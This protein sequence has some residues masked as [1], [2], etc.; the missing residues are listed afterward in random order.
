MNC[1]V[2]VENIVESH[3]FF[4]RSVMI[5]PQRL[6]KPLSNWSRRSLLPFSTPLPSNPDTPMR[7]SARVLLPTTF[8]VLERG[9]FHSGKKSNPL[10]AID[11]RMLSD[12]L[13]THHD[14]SFVYNTGSYLYINFS[15]ESSPTEYKSTA[16]VFPDGSLVTWY[17]PKEEEIQLA[18]EILSLHSSMCKSVTGSGERAL[19]KFESVDSMESIPVSSSLS[20]DASALVDGDAISLTAQD[21]NRSNEMLAVSMAIRS[22]VRMNVIE[23]SLKEYIKQGHSDISSRVAKLSQW[24]L[25][26]VSEC[27]FDAEQAVHKW[28]YF[29][30]STNQTGV[31]DALWEYDQLDRLFDQVSSHFEIDERYQD[32]QNQIT[33]YSEFLR[34]VGDFVRHG[35]SSRLEKIIILIIAVEAILAFRHMVVDVYGK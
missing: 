23:S 10:N 28:R 33:Y 20:E 35:Y 15:S 1:D 6:L 25:S 32:L 14:S 7:V 16:V 11:L 29:L 26:Q 30:T 31:P 3:H 18:S 17:M 21:A 13:G 34:T 12:R 2:R 4:S 5:N 9:L 24:Q 8:D 19:D 27:V 22:A